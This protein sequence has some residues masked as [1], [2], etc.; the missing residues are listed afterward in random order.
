M[1]SAKGA[2]VLGFNFIGCGCSNL[3]LKGLEGMVESFDGR[4]WILTNGK[5]LYHCEI[6][7]PSSFRLK[8]TWLI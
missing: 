2:S 3:S 8:L 7:L 1:E 4:F 6:W 5:I